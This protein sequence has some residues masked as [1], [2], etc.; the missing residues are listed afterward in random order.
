VFVFVFCFSFLSLRTYKKRKE[1]KKMDAFAKKTSNTPSS[2]GGGGDGGAKAVDFRTPELP[3]L[4]KYR[5]KLMSDI[6]GNEEAVKRL[7]IIA[8]EGNL[9]NII[10][11]VSKNKQPNNTTPP[12]PP[13]Q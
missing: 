4:E 10:I 3:W 12:K 9:P 6:V 1:K 2:G 5:P 8:K 13:N 7:Q 11:A